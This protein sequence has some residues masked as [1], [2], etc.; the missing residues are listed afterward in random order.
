MTTIVRLGVA[1]GVFDVTSPVATA[2]VLV[3]LVQGLNEDATGLFLALEAGTVPLEHLEVRLNAYTE[4]FER[5]L[6]ASPGT[7][8]FT[9]ISV[10]RD[11]QR[12]SETYRKEHA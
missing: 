2:R 6:G 10:I 7:I 5:I 12:W 4:A 8:R 11:W 3:S 1:E 9:N